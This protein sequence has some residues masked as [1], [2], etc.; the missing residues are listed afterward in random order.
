MLTRPDQPKSGKIVTRPDPTRPDPT[1]PAGPSDPW[2][3]LTHI[4]IYRCKLV[5]RHNCTAAIHDWCRARKLQLN[6]DKTEFIWFGS[7]HL[8]QKIPPEKSSILVCGVQVSPVSCVR[9][10]GVLL[11]S[12]LDMKS[13]IYSIVSDGFYHLRRLRQLRRIL[14]RDLRQRLVS[15]LILSRIDYCNA[16]LV[17]LPASSLKSLQRTDQSSCPLCCWSRTVWQCV[18][19]I[20]RATLAP[21]RTKNRI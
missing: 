5:C 7:K 9:N 16:V 10:L 12:Q 11:D 1:R 6:P 21:D 3:T 18:R 17:G 14:S 13:H 15:A 4:R 20:E 19:N 2:T 8:L